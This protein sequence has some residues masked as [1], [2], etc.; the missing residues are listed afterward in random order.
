V[1]QISKGESLMK[2][3]LDHLITDHE[4]IDNYRPAW[5]EGL[6]LDR[7]YPDL[8][9]AFEY[10]G[11]QHLY[12]IPEY[13]RRLADLKRRKSADKKKRRLC[14]KRRILLVRIYYW[15]LSCGQ[16]V[17][18]VKRRAGM[19]KWANPELVALMSRYRSKKRGAKPINAEC[20]KYKKVIKANYESGKWRKHPAHVI[21]RQERGFC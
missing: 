3:V 5:L 7:H 12:F 11:F 16:V 4:F 21:R 6:E 14:K 2:R 13:H 15:Q 8:R 19:R 10:Q 9:L 18:H 17:Q 20:R 1:T